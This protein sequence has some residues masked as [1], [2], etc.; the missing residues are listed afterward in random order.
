VEDLSWFFP[1]RFQGQCQRENG[2]LSRPLTIRGDLSV[3]ESCYLLSKIES[4]TASSY[5]GMLI[6]VSALIEFLEYFFPLSLFDTDPVVPETDQQV[7]LTILEG[8]ADAGSA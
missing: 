1:F 3:M 7:I 4:D 8:Y 6:V 5:G 2:S